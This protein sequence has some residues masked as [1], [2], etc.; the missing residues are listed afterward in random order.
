MREG[1][2]V[3][4]GFP[5]AFKGGAKG[6]LTE[7]REGMLGSPPEVRVGEEE[8]RLAVLGV[9]AVGPGGVAVAGGAG[10]EAAVGGEEE[11]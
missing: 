8:A 4:D 7:A 6:A 11:V 1:R 9:A 3:G 5:D 10:A 2:A